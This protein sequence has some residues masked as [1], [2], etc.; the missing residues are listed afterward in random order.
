MC[1]WCGAPISGTDPYS[2]RY[3]CSR[4]CQSTAQK[5]GRKCK[6]CMAPPLP[7]RHYCADCCMRTCEH[8][9]ATFQPGH[10]VRSG[11]AS[12]PAFCSQSCYIASRRPVRKC[13]RCGASFTVRATPSHVAQGEGRFCSVKC[14]RHGPAAA[15]PTPSI[16]IK[17][18]MWRHRAVLV[19]VNRC[20]ECKATV[21]KG[22]HRCR[23]CRLLVKYELQQAHK[24]SK[25][26]RAATRRAKAR[27]KR[28][29]LVAQVP[30]RD[31]DIFERDAYRCHFRNTNQCV[32]PRARCKPTAD[33]M[34]DDWAPTIDHILPL[35]AGGRDA[36]DNVACAHRKCNWYWQHLGTTQ[37][38]LIS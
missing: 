7:G 3:Y 5:K 6:R 26:G 29:T 35:Q 22:A 21:A 27:R 10:L 28:R 1:L 16:T 15:A 31:T 23:P 33:R 14:A 4:R 36:P 13:E 19:R 17:Q 30:Y 12:S 25:A 34:L 2:S 9:G 38:R 18:W 20:R 24:R 37:L 32:M 11:M 8:C